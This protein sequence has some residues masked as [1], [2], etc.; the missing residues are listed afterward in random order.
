MVATKMLML[1]QWL[2]VYTDCG[3]NKIMPYTYCRPRTVQKCLLHP[4]TRVK[5]LGFSCYLSLADR[6]I[7][8]LGWNVHKM[9][10]ILS[11]MIFLFNMGEP[12]L[13]QSKIKI[14][15]N[16]KTPDTLSSEEIFG[17]FWSGSFSVSNDKGWTRATNARLN[18]H[19]FNSSCPITDGDRN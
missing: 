4:S 1:S 2:R 10:Y 12:L 9:L 19:R 7:L 14:Q 15:Q 11:L 18:V 5:A 17:V 6:S 13:F 3:K 16:P 8:N